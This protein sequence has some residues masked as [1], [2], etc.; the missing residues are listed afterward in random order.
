MMDPFWMEELMHS[1]GGDGASAPACDREPNVDPQALFQ[2]WSLERGFGIESEFLLNLS[3]TTMTE[4]LR[5]N[6]DQAGTD[7]RD[8]WNLIRR[9]ENHL[10]KCP[11]HAP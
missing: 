3:V 4:W 2:A 6:Q 10:L 1:A 11:P 8:I 7:Q 5:S 9:I